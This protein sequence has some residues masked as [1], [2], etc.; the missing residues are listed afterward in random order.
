MKVIESFTL[1]LELCSVILGD[2]EW[3]IRA[4]KEL[5][6]AL[7]RTMRT[8]ICLTLDRPNTVLLCAVAKM[9][10]NLHQWHVIDEHCKPDGNVH[11]RDET[12]R[13]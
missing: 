8:D 10:G 11:L 6:H 5:E 4:S 12:A 3:L 13:C 1:R 2:L 9:D 7:E